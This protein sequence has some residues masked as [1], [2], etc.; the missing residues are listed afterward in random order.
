MGSL[1][2]PTTKDSAY[3][4]TPR[5][6]PAWHCAESVASAQFDQIGSL[7]R[8]TELKNGRIR[9]RRHMLGLILRTATAAKHELPWR[10]ALSS[11]L[12]VAAPT[13]T[14]S[15]RPPVHTRTRLPSQPHDQCECFAPAPDA[16]SNRLLHSGLPRW[17]PQLAQ[18]LL[19]PLPVP[20]GF[21]V[22]ALMQ[23]QS[24]P[25][26]EYIDTGVSQHSRE[27]QRHS[28]QLLK[29]SARVRTRGADA[30][31]LAVGHMCT[32]E[33]EVGGGPRRRILRIDIAKRW[34]LA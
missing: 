14:R 27:K 33:R 22:T 23:S 5:T 18:Y 6:L 29:G 8:H 15:T 1:H 28:R 12:L 20:H 13:P 3:S 32:R 2:L 10:Q 17:R 31:L 9:I 30:A 16:R 25:T 21:R 7:A 34:P 24:F 26:C 19:A 4:Y 11:T